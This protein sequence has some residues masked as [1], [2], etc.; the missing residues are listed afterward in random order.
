L[1]EDA[2]IIRRVLD[3]HI[4]EYDS[5]ITRYASQVLAIVR[6]RVPHSDV[7]EVAHETFID[8]YRS[9]PG[10]AGIKPFEH[11]LSRIAVRRCCDY[12]RKI[13]RRKE[14]RDGPL[15]DRHTDWLEQAAV[16]QSIDKHERLSEQ[17]EAGEIIEIALGQLSPENRLLMDLLYLQ[18]W[19]LKETAETMQWSI[20]KV[21]VRAFRARQKMREI[22]DSLRTTRV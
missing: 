11:W 14:L 9:L 12:W 5:L 3:G 21:K 2:E 17:Q 4:H 18:G 19:S 15:D 13:E 10:Y 8:A 1:K 16:A 22:I 20:V 7:E 6:K